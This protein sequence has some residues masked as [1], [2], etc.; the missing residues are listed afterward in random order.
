MYCTY[1][2]DKGHTT[3]QCQVLKDHLGQLVKMGYLKKFVVDSGDK[4]TRQGAQ[5][6]GNPPPP[7]LGVIEVIHAAPRD[8]A[9]A[10]SRGV[11]TIAPVGNC[12]GEQPTEKKMKIGWEPI[13]FYDDDLEGIIQPHD[14][15]LVV[16][17]WINNLIVK[18]VMMDQGSGADVMYPD[19]FK[20]LGLKNEDL[21]RYDTPLVGFDGQ[22][23]IPDGQISLLVTMEGKDV[24]VA[25]IVVAL[26]SPYMA[27]LGR[28]WI[29]TMGEVPSTLH[30]KIKFRTE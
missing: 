14:D 12:L 13:A 20:G 10:R 26:F 21:L 27:I 17:A 22:M 29:H 7:S 19:L 9:M 6:R 30:V 23:V 11:L 16:T 1:H 8:A 28:L 2:R 3:E 15:A 24:T 5:Q 25:F 4:D 18:R